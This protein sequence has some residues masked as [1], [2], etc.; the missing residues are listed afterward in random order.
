MLTYRQFLIEGTGSIRHTVSDEEVQRPE[1]VHP[2]EDG[3]VYY[4]NS[5]D[6]LHR[7]GA[8][9]VEYND[10]RRWWFVN[11]KLHRLDGPAMEDP[12]GMYEEYWCIN[13]K[14]MEDAGDKEKWMLLKANI[15]RN[16][17]I[18]NQIRMTP[19]MQEYILQHRPDLANQIDD[20]DPD[21]KAKYQHEVGLSN[22]D[23]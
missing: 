6:Q 21:L 1:L 14:D 8:P 17:E 10:G 13:G 2:L 16:L 7:V 4:T 22:A 5:N 20:L 15:P 3:D 18:L 19:E 23:L 11:G 9:A 12:T